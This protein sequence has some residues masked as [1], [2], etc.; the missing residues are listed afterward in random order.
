MPTCQG[1]AASSVTIA[2]EAVWIIA[3]F[4]WEDGLGLHKVLLLLIGII[5]NTYWRLIGIYSQ[6][7][8]C[9]KSASLVRRDCSPLTPI[10]AFTWRPALWCP[11]G[12]DGQHHPVRGRTCPSLCS[13]Q[14]QAC[15]RD[16]SHRHP[17]PP[18]HFSFPPDPKCITHIPLLHGP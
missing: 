8:P 5:S 11:G 16:D 13:G 4:K 12:A 15:H 18:A 10:P 7:V 9:S 3:L 6:F 1:L 14:R 17:S 2:L